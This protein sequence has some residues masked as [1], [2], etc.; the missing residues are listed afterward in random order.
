MENSQPNQ[1]KYVN[2]HL[3]V[4]DLIQFSDET[5]PESVIDESIQPKQKFEQQKGDPSSSHDSLSDDQDNAEYGE[6]EYLQYVK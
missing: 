3:I 2:N 1:Q 5:D 4:N 6:A